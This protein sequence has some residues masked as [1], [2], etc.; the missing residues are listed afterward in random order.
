MPKKKVT[1]QEPKFIANQQAGYDAPSKH[2]RTRDGKYATKNR[3]IEEN[4]LTSKEGFG[5]GTKFHFPAPI[6]NNFEVL[7]ASMSSLADG[8]PFSG[9]AGVLKASLGSVEGYAEKAQTTLDRM[10]ERYQAKPADEKNRIA[11]VQGFDKAPETKPMANYM[12]TQMLTRMNLAEH[13]W[14]TDGDAMNVCETPIEILTRDVDVICPDR[15]LR[16]DIEDFR[17]QYHLVER[18]AELWSV[19]REY[20][21]SYPFEVWSES[22]KELVDIVPLPPKHVHIG[23]NWAYGLSSMMVGQDEWTEALLQAVFPPAMFRILQRHWNDSPIATPGQGAFLPGDNLRPIFDKQRSWARYSMP[24][25]SRGFRELVSRT[26]YEDSVRALV[27]GMRYQLWVIKV[28]D[29]DH[30]P[31]PQEIAAVKDMLNAM[32]GEATGMFVWRDSPLQVEVHI[33][34]G[35]DQMIG[36]D[37]GGVMTKQFFRKMGITAEVISGETPGMLGGSGGRG[38]S[39]GAKGDIDVQIYIERARYQASQVTS[40][41]EYLV[42]KWASLNSKYAQ[43]NIQKIRLPFKPT[44]IEMENR[45]KNVFGP[46][47]RDG[48]LSHRDY[49]A[50]AGLDGETVI[51]QKRAEEKDR[52]I[53]MPPVSYTQTVVNADGES[54]TTEQTEPQG[55]P[56]AAGEQNNAIKRRSRV[57]SSAQSQIVVPAPNVTVNMGAQPAPVT[58]VSVPESVVNVTVPER[59]VNVTVEGAQIPATVVN[60]PEQPPTVVNVSVPEQPA[61]IV[62]VAAPIV[63]VPKQSAPKVVVEAARVD[64]PAPIVNVAPAVVHVPEQPAPVVNIEAAQINVPKPEAPII[65]VNVPKQP[66]PIVNVAPA[67]VSVTNDVSPTPVTVNAEVKMPDKSEQKIEFEYNEFGR[68]IGAK[69]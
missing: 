63:N 64:I 65:Q 51:T 68:I 9:L 5:G 15:S 6:T 37:Y 32:S 8:S 3:A 48:A 50:A 47:Y 29:A 18:M 39:G 12:P 55:S 38:G 19:M 1:P 35:L 57:T 31:L 52:D 67:A 34:K 58:N 28:G 4:N 13:Y 59:T 43:K 41:A 16:R 2:W 69:G 56:D 45:V 60:V 25:L 44:V 40:W 27:E 54:S 20:G 11:A 23:Y 10:W 49:V 46:M 24:M 66:A 36:N 14:N 21:Q 33:P 22:G 42:R 17:D 30:P 61:P 26:V 7:E 53:L 62:N